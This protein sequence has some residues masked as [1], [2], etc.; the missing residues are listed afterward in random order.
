MGRG[1]TDRVRQIVD[2]I[3]RAGGAP[4]RYLVP[5]GGGYLFT[6]SGEKLTAAEFKGVIRAFQSAQA[7]TLTP[8]EKA[9]NRAR[10]VAD[11]HDP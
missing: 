2:A 1:M 6:L 11:R 9:R 5:H 8:E 3:R 10:A 4:T 7:S